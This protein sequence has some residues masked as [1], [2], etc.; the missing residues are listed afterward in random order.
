[1]NFE[2]KINHQL[3]KYPLLKKMVKRGYQ[4]LMY[5]ISPKMKS[6]GNI[7]RISP[8]D[9][10]E[11]FFGYYDKSPW[12]ASGKKILCMRA[13]NTWENVAP[14][15]AADIL[16]ID[17]E[18][19]RADPQLL[20][21]THCW[22]VQ[23]GCMAQWLGP[24]YCSRIIYNDFRNGEFCA[25]IL[26]IH[27][28]SE[29]VI[30]R[31]I[32]TVSS[33]GKTALTLDFARLH[34]LRPGYGYSNL[35]DNTK[36]QGLPDETCIWRVDLENGSFCSILKYTDLASF[37]PRAE[38]ENAEHKV[39][40]LMLSPNGQRFMVL[41]RWLQG[42]RKYTRLLT[43]NCDGTGLYNLSDDDMV[44]HCYWKNDKEIIA[45]ENKRNSGPGYYLM[46]DQT[47]EYTHLWKKIRN[48]G[49]PSYSPDNQYVVID[50]YPNRARV[51]E[52]KVIKDSD[53]DAKNEKVL[54]KVFSPFKYDNDTRCDLHPRWSRDGKQICFD[55]VFEGHRGLYMVPLKK[56]K[57]RVVFLVT[58]CAKLGP[59]QQTLNIIKH[60]N[61]D[62]FEPVLVTINPEPT[63][64][65]SQLERFLPY[66][67]HYY[68]PTGKLNI[69]TGRTQNLEQKLRE[70]RP[71]VIHSLG[72]FPDYAV[73]RMRKFKHIITLRN[74]VYDD[75]P[76]KFGKVQGHILAKLHLYAMKHTTKTVTCSE[77]LSQIYQNRLGL[78]YDFIRNG[79]DVTQY[80]CTTPAEREK[81]RKE[82]NIPNDEFV[83][84]YSGQIIDRKNQ[85]FLLEVFAKTFADEKKRLILLG[86]GADLYELKKQYGNIANVEFRGSVTNV[87]DYLK[88]SDVYVSTSKSEGMPNGVLEAMA[89]GLPVIL[90]D[91]AQ[92]KEIFSAEP[93]IGYLYRQNDVDNLSE[94]MRK[95]TQIDLTNM[96]N[97]SSRAAHEIF[98]ASIMSKQYQNQYC[99]LSQSME[100][101]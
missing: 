81:Y 41:H 32:Y 64:G 12:D 27:D 57:T 7:I 73:T 26:N 65:S 83:F 99:N 72:V 76:V 68:V 101:D 1:M 79:V 88:A 21:T 77:S 67:S 5:S 95:I 60:M 48:D 56:E 63:D 44:S 53:V 89:T 50:S 17:T 15:E 54:A 71:D 40:H 84:V 78:K 100:A 14:F 19:L 22:N 10:L 55:S 45:F 51:Q 20:A 85:K 9:S 52:I 96:S 29:K 2:Q 46:Q 98:S 74:Y 97:F 8:D 30:P 90:S 58:K 93:G 25:V 24:D 31:P 66:V 23:Q 18:N 3:N 33:D 91:I 28:G 47:Q 42:S 36:K 4:L 16:L 6:E 69:V 49:H 59:I 35:D 70:I 37:E 92:H 80:S 39:N 87:S 61:P 86:D 62:D 34:R 94:C 75:Y 43:C 38:M 13:K 82:L 11:Y